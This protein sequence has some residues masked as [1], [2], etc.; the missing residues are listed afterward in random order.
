[1][2]YIMTIFWSFLLSAAVSYVLSSMGG[3]P[4]LIENA[5]ILTVIFSIV[6]FVLGEGI[7]KEKTE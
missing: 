1:M 5:I 4:F 6:V 2:R 3:E 7:L